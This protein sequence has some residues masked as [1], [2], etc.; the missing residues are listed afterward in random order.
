MAEDILQQQIAYYRARAG[1][2]DEWFYRLNRYDN[3]PELNARWFREA[4]IVMKALESLG[5][6][7]NT[8]EI[9]CGTGIWTQEL[10]KISDHITALDAVAEVLAINKAKL[11]AASVTYQQANVFAWEPGRQYDMVFFGFWLSHV[12][13]ERLTP[14]LQMVNRALKPGGRIFMVDS[15]PDLAS[16]AKDSPRRDENAT[17]FQ[18]RKLNDGNLYTIVKIY[19]EVDDLRAKLKAAGFN[20]DVHRTAN[21]FI[22]ASGVKEKDSNAV[23]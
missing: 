3:G 13:P 9:A 15:T 11:G 1:E 14:F 6:F 5:H 21:S 10:V 16:S 4:G 23:S 19:Y 20:A 7:E 8:L 17:I 2:Y 18:K 22:Y 12:P